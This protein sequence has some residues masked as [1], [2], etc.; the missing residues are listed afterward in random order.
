MTCVHSLTPEMF[1]QARHVL[2]EFC[3]YLARLNGNREG[4]DWVR[5]RLVESNLLL[6][7]VTE[8]PAIA[9]LIDDEEDLM[10]G[11]GEVYD[12]NNSYVIR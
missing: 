10:E 8:L 12:S 1:V 5:K 11:N 2:H 7:P 6:E 4:L 3:C 9:E